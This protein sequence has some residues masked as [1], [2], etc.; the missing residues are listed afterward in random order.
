[1]R[2]MLCGGGTAG[3]INP[4]ISVAEELKRSH[5]DSEILF[6]GR[7]GGRENELVK[8]QGFSIKTIRIQGLRRSLSP[9]NLKSLVY[10]LKAKRT[11]KE[12]IREFNPDVILGTGGYVCWP[13]ISAGNELN[14]KTAIHE[15]NVS[16]GLTTKLLSKKTDLVLLNQKETADF[17]DK[18]VKKKVVGNPIRADFSKFSRTSARRRL[19]IKEN[20]LLIVSFG[21][22]I[23]SEKMNDV[24]LKVMKDYSAKETDVK[25]IHSTGRRY[26]SQIKECSFR[27]ERNGC[28]VLPYI[29]DM[30]IWLSAADIAI[31]RCGAVTLSEICAAGVASILIPS[32]NVTDNH[33]YK[34]AAYLSRRGGAILIEE[35]NLTPE[36]LINALKELK[37]DKNERKNKA[38]ISKSFS[39][40]KAATEVVNQLFL[41]KNGR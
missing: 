27:S 30:P 1:M 18:K 6:I 15:S 24:I 41:L 16:P 22:S 40:P 11:A 28:R 2:V 19:G 32:P 13:V 26:Y 29:E 17:L 9:K 23:G 34:N 37:S 33:Q 36:S 21:G 12:L 8:N 7:E 31:C 14:V 10:A 38:K 5:P 4:A 3:H 25:H 35:K 20:E 39:T